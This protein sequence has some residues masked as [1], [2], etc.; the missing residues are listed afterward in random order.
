MKSLPHVKDDRKNMRHTIKAMMNIATENIIEVEDGTLDQLD[1][2]QSNLRLQFQARTRKL[3]DPRMGILADDYG[4]TV[5]KGLDWNR[6]KE[7]VM[8]LG[9]PEDYI[10][11][12]KG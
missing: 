8:K 1:N 12:S 2:V 10:V 3:T 7:Q 9:A 11:V 5:E 6:I 4:K